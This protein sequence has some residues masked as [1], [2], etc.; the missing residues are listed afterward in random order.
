[1]VS[2]TTATAEP[3]PADNLATVDNTP[4]SAV[5]VSVQSATPIILS[6]KN[7]K[8]ITR[9]GVLYHD[10]GETDTFQG[11][12]LRYKVTPME[13]RRANKMLGNNLKL[14]PSKLVIPTTDDTCQKRRVMEPTKEEKIVALVKEVSQVAKLTY[15]EARAYLE[16]ADWDLGC[17]IGNAKEGF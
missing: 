10:V 13:L 17:A 15:S 1:M 8:N 7:K 14:A 11:I 2:M 5:P 6:D 12:C 16:L 3:L 9:T 4:S